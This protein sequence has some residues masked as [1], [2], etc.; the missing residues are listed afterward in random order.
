MASSSPYFFNKTNIP[1][2]IGYFKSVIIFGDRSWF[3]VI[4][5]MVD[6]Y[7]EFGDYKNMKSVEVSYKGR[8]ILLYSFGFG[9]VDLNR[10]VTESWFLGALYFIFL[11]FSIPLLPSS[12]IKDKD[13][14]TIYAS[15]RNESG[16]FAEVDYRYPAVAHP[17][18]V[19]ALRTSSESLGYTLKPQKSVVVDGYYEKKVKRP[20]LMDE[21]VQTDIELQ[22]WDSSNMLVYSSLRKVKSGI[23][24][25][26]GLK[27][28]LVNMYGEFSDFSNYNQ[29]MN[30]MAKIALEACLL[31]EPLENNT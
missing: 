1:P 2:R 17:T 7:I 16:T 6:S 13:I 23:L 22:D 14:F 26:V 28:N 29:Q 5:P 18:I 3:D 24:T 20:T 9:F 4:L 19:R 21:I 11:N 30:L 31:V 8:K 27:P 25:C 10:V 15:C 12:Q